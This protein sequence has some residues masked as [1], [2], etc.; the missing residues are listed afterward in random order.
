MH[1][2]ARPA[3]LALT[4]LLLMTGCASDRGSPL[5]GTHWRV[6]SIDGEAPAVPSVANMR[7]DTRTVAVSLGCNGIGGA[8]RV[9]GKRLIAGPFES[10]EKSCDGEIASQEAAVRALL[11][12][13]P[14]LSLQGQQMRLDSGGHTIDLARQG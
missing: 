12:A 2:F 6:T 3:C 13:A 11:A 14:V 7:F 4:A 8:Y 10:T 1:S 9:D 5:A